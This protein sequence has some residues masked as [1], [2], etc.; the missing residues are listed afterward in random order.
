MAKSDVR[1]SIEQA[2]DDWGAPVVGALA[3]AAIGKKIT[4][5][6]KFKGDWAYKG[7]S[8]EPSRELSRGLRQQADH[9]DH[10]G[11]RVT[12]GGEDVSFEWS[13]KFRDQ[14]RRVDR[15]LRSNSLIVAGSGAAGASGSNFI[16]DG[17]K[18]KIKK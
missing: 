13:S 17:M 5:K 1:S 10:G 18:R 12:R 11:A 3:G 15:M 8:A 16:K 7:H 4:G 14:A 2:I 9:I 6:R